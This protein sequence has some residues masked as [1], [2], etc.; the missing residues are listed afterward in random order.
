MAA[1]RACFPELG[2]HDRQMS[3]FDVSAYRTI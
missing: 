2:V 3:S 1:W